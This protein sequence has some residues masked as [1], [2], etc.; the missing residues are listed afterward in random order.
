MAEI[1]EQKQMAVS[2][3]E[4]NFSKW[5]QMAKC[6]VIPSWKTYLKLDK[7]TVSYV[8]PDK[9]CDDNDFITNNRGKV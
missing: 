2:N 9:L 4:L 5:Y 8:L 6:K 3:F 1:E 7:M